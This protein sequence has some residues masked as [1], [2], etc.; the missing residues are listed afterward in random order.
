MPFVG[1]ARKPPKVALYVKNNSYR[2]L[3]LHFFF[4]LLGVLLNSHEHFKVE[5]KKKKA[6][7]TRHFSD[8]DCGSAK[9]FSSLPWHKK[10][11]E[12]ACKLL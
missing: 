1:L 8:A 7:S 2:L 6:F 11:V 10:I 3:F 12:V 4:S 5:A 9:N